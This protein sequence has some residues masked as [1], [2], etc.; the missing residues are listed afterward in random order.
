VV[1][2]Q[3]LIVVD[4]QTEFSPG[5]QREVPNHAAAIAA[6]ARHVARAR[7]EG[8]PVAWVRH[9]NKPHESQAFVPGSWGSE[10][11]PG[12]GPCDTNDEAV[13]VKEVYGAFSGTDLEP[14]LRARGVDALL[15]VG[16]YAHMCLATAAREALVR[17]FDVT[18][19]PE[20][21]GARALA[22]PVLGA[23]SAGEVLRSSLL[24]VWNMG[25][26]VLPGFEQT[27]TGG[28]R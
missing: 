18:V 15:L 27:A 12:F 23:Q 21:T 6:I 17:G 14:W 7:R 28:G 13:F 16:F 25:A 24:H 11:T 22:H 10:L 3:A 26:C 20:A 1:V 4:A 19:D 9:H 8:W 5:G 2:G